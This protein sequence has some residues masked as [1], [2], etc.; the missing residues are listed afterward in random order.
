MIYNFPDFTVFFIIALVIALTVSYVAWLRRPAP[1]TI[2]FAIFGLAVAWWIFTRIFEAGGVDIATKILWGKLSFF[3]S[4]STGVFWLAFATEYAGLKWWRKPAN[5]FLLFLLPLLSTLIIWTMSEWVWPNIYFSPGAGSAILIWEHGLWFWVIASYNY[6]LVII[7]IVILFRYV[8]KNP[9]IYK[10]Q[11]IGILGG[12]IFPLIINILYVLGVISLKGADL[13]PFV[14]VLSGLIY[15]FIIFRFHFFEIIPLARNT[16]VETLP[17]GIVVL[18]DKGY[19]A[20]INPAA[21]KLM[22]I[23]AKT[24]G[25][26]PIEKLWPSWSELIPSGINR[27]GHT[28]LTSVDN[29]NWHHLEITVTPIKKGNSVRG[30]LAI[31]RDISARRMMQQSLQESESRYSALVN[32]LDESVLII[33]EGIFVFAN[34]PVAELTGYRIDD[35]IGKPFHFLVAE[36]DQSLVRENYRRR[37]AG[38]SVPTSYDIRIMTRS[39]RII[40]V[41]LSINP[42]TYDSSPAFLVTLHELS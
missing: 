13:T 4:M 40:P 5:L 22:A 38:E 29:P 20:D 36:E 7:G 15:S 9:G 35:I 19:I 37:L 3:G 24:S 23:P 28:V 8:L 31:L 30:R 14:F 16:L 39:T 21:A 32:Q 42:I 17:E 10:K 25:G 27:G 18:D 12:I 26:Y 33:R 6:L 11:V 34:R 41:K 1:G 2:P